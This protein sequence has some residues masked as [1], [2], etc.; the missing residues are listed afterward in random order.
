MLDVI[1]ETVD[2]K[3]THRSMC[4]KKFEYICYSLTVCFM[5][6]VGTGKNDGDD[7]HNNNDS[8]DE[9]DH[10]NDLRVPPDLKHR[11]V[12]P[13]SVTIFRYCSA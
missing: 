8:G 4:S 12:L 9:N 7:D 1:Y 2:E 3:F 13:D 11:P 6:V 5:M 10:N